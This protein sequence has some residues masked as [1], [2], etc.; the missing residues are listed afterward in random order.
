MWSLMNY[1]ESLERENEP[2]TEEWDELEK[3]IIAK[4]AD[5]VKVWLRSDTT[6]VVIEKTVK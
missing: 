5:D 4:L 1:R 3:S 2:D 6:E